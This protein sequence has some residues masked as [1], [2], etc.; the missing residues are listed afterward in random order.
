[1]IQSLLA[2]YGGL[3]SLGV[4]IVLSALLLGFLGWYRL[5]LVPLLAILCASC[6]GAF[7]FRGW[8]EWQR[9]AFAPSS[10]EQHQWQR[11]AIGLALLLLLFVFLVRLT[12]W[13]YSSLGR[14][15]P[16]DLTAYHGIKAIELVRSGSYWDLS[17]P[18]GE[19][20]V[21]YEGLLAFG[22]LLRGDFDSWGVVH[23]G[24]FLLGYLSVYLLLR[25]GTPVPSGLA[26]LLA[27]ATF[28]LPDLYSQVLQV[29][30]ND[31]LL[32]VLAL[33]ALVHVPWR[34]N[35]PQ[36]L[37]LAGVIL[38]TMLALSIKTTGVFFLLPLWTWIAWVLYRQENRLLPVLMKLILAG[39]LM[40]PG[41]LWVLRNLVLMGRIAGP[42]TSS[43]FGGSLLANL[44]HPLL[45]TSGSET[46]WLVVLSLILIGSS[47]WALRSDRIPRIWGALLLLGWL[48]FLATPLS[49]FLTPEKVL[50]NVQ[51][52]FV[53][54][55]LLLA[56]L[57]VIASFA[58][59]MMRAYQ[60]VQRIMGGALLWAPLLVA[61]LIPVAWLLRSPDWLETSPANATIYR[62]PSYEGAGADGYASAYAYVQREIRDS[63]IFY[64]LAESFYLYG[65]GFSNT[66][67]PGA[68][69]PIGMPEV[70][71][72]PEPDYLWIGSKDVE[73]LAMIPHEDLATDWHVVYEDER[74][75]IYQ[76]N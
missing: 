17:I 57:I 60:R 66:P 16:Q 63:V 21:G 27:L 47:L 70:A 13:P 40:L 35:R 72:H 38:A 8:R 55:L 33:A 75:R 31:V 28:F 41:L 24:I 25:R 71:E 74:V 48:G 37:H 14:V 9:Q 23:T 46:F 15:I 58:P 36:D 2:V 73:Y 18:Y 44:G 64:F 10:T 11:A 69:H 4:G 42:E 12:L 39:L 59:L 7:Y 51:W 52:R 6:A 26:A 1:M 3:L 20:P 5:P 45:W 53:P 61:A 22:L 29:G 76:R 56:A 50:L 19:Y 62:L 68:V 32:G 54:H 43:F 30:K 65:P 49:A 34:V 67:T